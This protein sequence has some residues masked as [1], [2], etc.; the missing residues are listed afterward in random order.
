M[1]YAIPFGS[2]SGKALRSEV[3]LAPNK[4]GLLLNNTELC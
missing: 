4:L 3:D 2:Q 1:F